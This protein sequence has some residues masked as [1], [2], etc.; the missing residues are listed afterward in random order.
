MLVVCSQ[1]HLN[2]VLPSRQ[3]RDSGMEGIGC[4]VVSS[5]SNDPLFR[6]TIIRVMLYNNVYIPHH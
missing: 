3:A 4:R 1:Q 2:I 6:D 5:I